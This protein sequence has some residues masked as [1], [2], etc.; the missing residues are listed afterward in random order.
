MPA[1]CFMALTWAAPPTRETERPTLMAGRIPALNRFG[2]QVDLAV[3]DGNDVGGDIRR[4]VARL[5]LDDG[6]GREGSRAL[7]VIASLAAALQQTGVEVEDV[8]RESLASGRTAQQQGHLPIGHGLLG[9]VVV[10]D[11]RVFA[12]VAVE[13][14]HGGIR[15]MRR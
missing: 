14:G 8:A 3:G 2:L 6:Q 5:G 12:L 15:S 11:Q 9:Q 1:T 13:L 10:D 4:D 7:G